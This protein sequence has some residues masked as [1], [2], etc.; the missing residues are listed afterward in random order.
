M[1]KIDTLNITARFGIDQ[2]TSKTRILPMQKLLLK[3]AF[4][5]SLLCCLTALSTLCHAQGSG[6]SALYQRSLAATCANCH[7]TNGKGV[8]GGGIPLSNQL[9]SAQMLSQLL[10]YKN[11][12]REGTIMPQL[13][14]GYSDEQ[15]ETITRQLGKQP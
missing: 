1:F 12:T 15:L 5:A 8:V 2:L 3:I 11:G 13:S 10:A 9:T 4:E 6:A 7:G 14:K